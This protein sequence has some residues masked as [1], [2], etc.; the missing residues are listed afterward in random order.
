MSDVAVYT[1][2]NFNVTLLYRMVQRQSPFKIRLNR[3]RQ[4]DAPFGV[5]IYI[6]KLFFGFIMFYIGYPISKIEDVIIGC[7]YLVF[8]FLTIYWWYIFSICNF[9]HCI[10]DSSACVCIMLLFTGMG[11]IQWLPLLMW[12]AYT[13]YISIWYNMSYVKTNFILS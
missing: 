13:F 12:S 5:N 9:R 4:Y 2:V 11:Q 7:L 1:V 3:I 6:M 10:F 8:W